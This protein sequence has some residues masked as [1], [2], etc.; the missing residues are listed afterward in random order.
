MNFVV[1][2]VSLIETAYIQNLSRRPGCP[3]PGRRA[4]LA[5]CRALRG[6]AGEGT[7]PYVGRGSVGHSSLTGLR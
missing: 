5:N 3:H 7:R 6:W 2:A 1:F 4:S